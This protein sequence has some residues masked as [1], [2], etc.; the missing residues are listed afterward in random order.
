MARRRR[1]KIGAYIWNEKYHDAMR[2][3]KTMQR[4]LAEINRDPDTT[5]KRLVEL[6]LLINEARDAITEMAEIA[7]ANYKKGEKK[8]E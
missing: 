8:D 5:H 2:F 7:E 4:E 3:L 1:Q 6:A